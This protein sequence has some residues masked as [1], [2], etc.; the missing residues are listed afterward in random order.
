ML[1]QLLRA[2]KL[3]VL[4]DVKQAIEEGV[5]VNA[6]DRYIFGKIILFLKK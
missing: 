5:D 6:Q 1:N 2:A 4:E 3:G